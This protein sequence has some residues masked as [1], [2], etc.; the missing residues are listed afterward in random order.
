MAEEA[1][2]HYTGWILAALAVWIVARCARALLASAEREIWA[3]LSPG[4]GDK[5]P[6]ERWEC[7]IGR[8]ARADVVLSDPAAEPT[9]ALLCRGTDG[10]WT[11]TDLS[12]GSAVLLGGEAVK[13]SAPLKSGDRLKLGKTSLR[14]TALAAPQHPD[15]EGRPVRRANSA[16]TLFLLTFFELAMLGQH[17]FTASPEHRA[18][19]LLAFALLIA[20]GWAAYF[21]GRGA[22]AWRFE[23]E[24]LAL[25]LTAVGFSVAASSVPEAMAK[26][27]ALFILALAGYFLLGLWLRESDRV[28]LVRPYMAGAAI[29]FL[30]LTLVMSESVMGAKNWLTVAGG[31][32]Q[33]SE[34]VKIAFVYAG[35]AGL[36]RMYKRGSLLLFTVFSAVCVGTLALMGDF[37]TA[38]VFFTAYL[39]ISFMR[40]GSFFLLALSLAGVG[41]AVAAVLTLRPYVAQRFA[42]WGHVWSD[43]L[44]AGYQQ[45]RAMSAMAAGGLFGRGAGSG[46]L[47]G[48]V[49]ADTDL[50]FGVVCEELGLITGVCCV[51]ALGL[52][53][54]Y[55]WRC[56]GA[57]RLAW[58]VTAGCAAAAIYMVQLCLNV[59][60]SMDLLPFTGVT[61]PFVS[62]GGSSLIACWGLLAFVKAADGRGVLNTAADK[63]PPVAK[64]TT[65]KKPAA[66]PAPAKPASA[67]KK[68]PSGQ[69]AKKKGAGK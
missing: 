60:G 53:C 45:V 14:F 44:G 27:S 29:V 48:I 10:N 66:K 68:A 55:C 50:V 38:L 40:S 28:A 9:H 35:A 67:P 33:P 2:L 61:F 42:S 41:A 59:F 16:A 17:C 19:V 69:A 64:P 34:F 43:P 24:I 36:D 51:A 63:K 54:L 52:L 7:V 6:L 62:R 32:L 15:A 8:S 20:L 4:K 56:A 1:F 49:A 25:F 21:I 46:W 18:G 31:S 5:L 11:V 26:Q 37:G 58:Y 22:G 23:P 12:R 47:T 3:F 57:G 30:G 39:V 65:A 13:G